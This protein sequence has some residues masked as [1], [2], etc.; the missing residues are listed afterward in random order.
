VL[1][2]LHLNKHELNLIELLLLLL[3]LA[4]AAAAAVVVVVVVV[5][6]ILG[7][8][9]FYMF[10]MYLNFLPLSGCICW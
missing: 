6:V 8:T 7:F 3:L 9:H 4:A 10:V 5:V 2:S 1:L